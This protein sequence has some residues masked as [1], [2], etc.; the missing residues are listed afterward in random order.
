MNPLDIIQDM[1]ESTVQ[2]YVIAGL[3][4]SLLTNGCV[5]LF[6]SQ[7]EHMDSITPHSHRFDLTCLVLSGYVHNHIWKPCPTG[8]E[9]Q[10]SWLEYEGDMGKH[11]RTQMESTVKYQKYT[12]R[13]DKGQWYSMAHDDIHSINFSRNCQVLLF[14]GPQ[15]YNNSVILEPVV[16]GKVIPTYRVEDWMFRRK[17]SA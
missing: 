5:R 16:D 11:K 13:Y 17:D 7:R 15:K 3:S 1:R 2:N 6:E 4:S 9:F 10:G 14:E 12:K 8:D